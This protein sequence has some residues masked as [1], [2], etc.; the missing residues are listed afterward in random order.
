MF[1]LLWA[2]D[3]TFGALICV[4]DY[5]LGLIAKDGILWIYEI[6]AIVR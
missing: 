2:V 5:G 6:L 4:I 3:G 1:L